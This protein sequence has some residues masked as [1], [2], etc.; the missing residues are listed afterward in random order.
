M[1][2]WF[3]GLFTGFFII[4]ILVYSGMSMGEIRI[5]DFITMGVCATTNLLVHYFKQKGVKI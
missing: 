2:F 5:I 3:S 1:Y 4:E